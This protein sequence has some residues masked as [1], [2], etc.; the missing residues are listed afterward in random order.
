MKTCVDCKLEKELSEFTKNNTF[1]KKC[2]YQR[3]KDK[4]RPTIKVI[5]PTCSTERD[6]RID[7]WKIRKTDM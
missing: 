1:C 3:Y 6:M 7:A 4:P 5:C 2:H